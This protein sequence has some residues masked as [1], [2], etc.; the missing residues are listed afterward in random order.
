[1]LI[2]SNRIHTLFHSRPGSE[3]KVLS[4]DIRTAPFLTFYDK[5][6]GYVRKNALFNKSITESEI[7]FQSFVAEILVD[8][9]GKPQ[10]ELIRLPIY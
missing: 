5:E 1:M 2:M 3:P 7:S 6:R 9:H 4:E 8:E 10:M